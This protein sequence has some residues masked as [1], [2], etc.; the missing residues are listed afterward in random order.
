[1]QTIVQQYILHHNATYVPSSIPTN[2][3]WG[4][5]WSNANSN[6]TSSELNYTDA[7][8]DVIK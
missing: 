3:E 1:M 6:D 7:D 5:K 2:I 4:I 8:H